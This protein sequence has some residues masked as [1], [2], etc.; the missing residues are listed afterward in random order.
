MLVFTICSNNYLAQATVLGNSLK[1]HNPSY[2]F[3]IVLVDE[4]TD[5][6]DYSKID[7]EIIAISEIEPDITELAI[8]YNI[9]ELNTCVKPKVF[10]Y[11]IR[12]RNAKKLV[13]FDPDIKIYSSLVEL[14]LLLNENNILL[15]PHVLTPIPFD[16]SAPS[17][18]LFL[19]YGIYNLGFAAIKDSAETL[20]FLSWWKDHTYKKGFKD[21]LNGIFVDQL[22]INLAPI[23]FKAVYIVR[24]PGYNMASWNLHERFLS[25]KNGVNYVN[26]S[27]KLF[28]YHFSSFK[29]DNI[30]LSFKGY[31]RFSLRNRPDLADIHNVYN[32][33]LKAADYFL[34][35]DIQCKYST[36]RCLQQPSFKKKVIRTLQ[37]RLKR[38]L[39][40]ERKG[41]WKD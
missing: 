41:S 7:H 27:D 24:N 38:V 25:N 19:N 33:E 39:N 4:K 16:N 2:K 20:A 5:K 40:L 17:E 21:V 18:N 14:E 34:F 23:F 8:K 37:T 30:E 6:I 35:K 9:I 32:D 10:Q 28:F 26:N 15:T 36:D 13:Y 29:V 22:P 3:L 1:K 31:W 12:E 11:L